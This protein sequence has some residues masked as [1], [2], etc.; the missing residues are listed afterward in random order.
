MLEKSESKSYNL[1]NPKEHSRT[2][3]N[4]SLEIQS[5]GTLKD[6]SQCLNW[7]LNKKSRISVPPSQLATEKYSATM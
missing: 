4:A 5:Q 1:D 3:P 6:E 7:D 2:N